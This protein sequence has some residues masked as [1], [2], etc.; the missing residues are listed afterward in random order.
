MLNLGLHEHEEEVKTTVEKAVKE[1]LMEKV[2]NDISALWENMNFDQEVHE[3]GGLTLIRASESLIELLEENQVQLQNMAT[4][5]YIAYFENDIRM[6]LNKLGNADH[7]IMTWTEVQRKWMYLES[8]FLGS[9]D[10]RKQLPN[11]AD[12]FDK[13]HQS[14]E[15]TLAEMNLDTN[16]MRVTGQ[17]GLTAKMEAI[18]RDLILCE[19]ALN[20]YLETKRLAYPRFYFISSSDLLDILSYGND[21]IAV[22]KHL[23]KLYDSIKRLQYEN[24]RRMA[25]GMH[26][27][28]HDEYVAFLAECDCSG[29]VEDWLNKVTEVMRFTLHELFAKSVV[30]Y[31]EKPR[32]AW[33]FDWPAQVALCI[34]QIWWSIEVNECFRKI[35]DGYENALKDY[36]R[37]QISQLNALI[38]LL[39]GE[40]NSVDRQKIM[41]ICTI[42]VHSR[43]VVAKMIAQKV[44]NTSAFQWQSQLRHRWDR[45]ENNCFVNIC[46]AQFK[47]DY[48]YLGVTPR[49]VIT[50]LTDR[51]YITLTQSLHLIYGGAP[52]G[53]VSLS[54]E[55]NFLRLINS[56]LV[57]TPGWHWKN[58]NH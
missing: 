4:S 2:I 8:I 52:A 9:K 53:P 29:R 45:A 51:C 18:L 16:V 42:D 7:V 49:L 32:E 26:S 33:V 39:L 19:K 12:R 44:I 1:M 13:T 35:G 46:D 58:R 20:E 40:L 43:D 57:G 3:H 34:T 6:W 27:K 41:T 47:Y 36:Q 56:F 10:I 55:T 24:E 28:E 21:P 25:I 17:V 23:T 38:T 30:A 54:T 31:D 48:E 15:N 14:F 22:G 50:P 37:K 11:D 5:K